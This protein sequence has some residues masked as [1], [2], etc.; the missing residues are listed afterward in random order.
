MVQETNLLVMMVPRTQSYSISIN[1]IFRTSDGLQT[2]LK[3][4]RPY[5][6]SSEITQPVVEAWKIVK[7]EHIQRE[8]D[9]HK[10]RR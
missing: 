3:A 4:I 9:H 5:L 1:K 8:A 7:R 2:L 6:T 10:A